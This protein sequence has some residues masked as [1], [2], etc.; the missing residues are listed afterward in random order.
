MPAVS[1]EFQA[2]VAFHSV[3][4]MSLVSDAHACFDAFEDADTPTPQQWPQCHRI[5]ASPRFVQDGLASLLNE[6]LHRMDR[7]DRLACMN[8]MGH[9]SNFLPDILSVLRVHGMTFRIARLHSLI[10]YFIDAT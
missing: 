1:L 9:L 7:T 10:A 3:R 4:V 5:D 6:W 2:V 8:R